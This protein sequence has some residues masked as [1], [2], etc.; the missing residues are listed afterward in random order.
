[1]MTGHARNRNEPP[2]HKPGEVARETRASR[3]LTAQIMSSRFGTAR[4]VVRNISAGGLGGKCD[5]LLFSG[6]DV[7]V[8]LNNIGAVDATIAWVDGHAFGLRF[9]E[10]IDPSRA[11]A[12]QSE[13]IVKPYEVPSYFRPEVS[14]YR[15]GFRTGRK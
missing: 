2:S 4:I 13:R 11:L 15:P 5:E 8:L 10:R 6:E 14:T 9:A 12:P 7:A 3:L 1:M